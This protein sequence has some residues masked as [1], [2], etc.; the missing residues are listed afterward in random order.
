MA[1]VIDSVRTVFTSKYAIFKIIFLSL[2]LAYPLYQIAMVKFDG[3]FST[4]SVAFEIA[5][6]FYVGYLVSSVNNY[7][8]ERYILLPSFINPFKI[9]LAGL[10]SVIAIGPVIMVMFYVGYCLNIIFANKGFPLP[11]AITGI[12]MIELILFGIFAAQMTLYASNFN[13]FRA[14]NL[15]QVVKLFPDYAL[16]TIGL[17]F[18]LV[19]FSAVILTPIGFLA[20]MMFGFNMVFFF[21]MIFF[22]TILLSLIFQYFA[23]CHVDVMVVQ[24]QV[25]YNSTEV[26]VKENNL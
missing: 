26:S 1:S 9:L 10:G 22:L 5:L 23:Q 17:T 7:I 3:W 16:K 25:D 24:R 14:Y 21:V 13:P 11:V 8:N 2:I 20:Q 12:V 4:W 15:I 6:I 18:G 19:L